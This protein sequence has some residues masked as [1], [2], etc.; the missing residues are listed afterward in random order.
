MDKKKTITLPNLSRCSV[1]S[2]ELDGV[3]GVCSACGH[4]EGKAFEDRLREDE[5]NRKKA[6]DDA[7]AAGNHGFYLEQWNISDN[8]V[9]FKCR[10]CGV[11]VKL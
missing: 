1:C 3:L 2:G 6:R 11:L 5:E 8:G 9:Y 10:N 7:C 4:D